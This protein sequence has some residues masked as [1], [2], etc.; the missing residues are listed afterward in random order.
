VSHS[1]GRARWSGP[2]CVRAVCKPSPCRA[3]RRPLVWHRLTPARRSRMLECFE[4]SGV[5]V[6]DG[7]GAGSARPVST[8][9][10]PDSRPPPVVPPRMPLKCFSSPHPPQKAFEFQ[11]G[12]SSPNDGSWSLL[13]LELSFASVGRPFR[14]H[15]VLPERAAPQ[16]GV[17]NR[18]RPIY[19]KYTP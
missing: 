18:T 1:G 15:H 4:L 6:L 5:L 19:R 10:F 7:E 12:G 14:I 2:G 17:T 16:T 8:R 9:K 3:L 11:L 13:I